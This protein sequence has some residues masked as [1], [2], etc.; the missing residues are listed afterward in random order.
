[1]DNK[2]QLCQEFFSSQ[3]ELVAHERISHR[4]NKTI[5]HRKLLTQPPLDQV[6]FYQDAFIVL[7]KKRLGFNRHSIGAKQFSINAFSENIF[8]EAGEQRLKQLVNY[9]QWN[10]RQ[11]PNW[12]QSEFKENN[13]IFQCGTT[14][15]KFTADSGEFSEQVLK[16]LSAT[17]NQVISQAPSLPQVHQINSNKNDKTSKK[18]RFILPCV[19]FQRL[20]R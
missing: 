10:I 19:P 4:N 9:D 1:M 6:T 8:G 13:R 14:T 7:I 16:D 2:C 11:D 5:P 3:K 18:Y 17:A 12:S 20:N 15:C